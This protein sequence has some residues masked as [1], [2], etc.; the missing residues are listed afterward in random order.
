MRLVEADIFARAHLSARSTTAGNE[1]LGDARAKES[2]RRIR[3]K[4][5]ES[6]YFMN[7]R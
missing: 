3:K 7:I 5:E 4:R 2:P 1:L 6:P